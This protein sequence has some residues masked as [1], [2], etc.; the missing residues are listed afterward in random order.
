[1]ADRFLPLWPVTIRRTGFSMPDPL[2]D[3]LRRRFD[4]TP[5][6]SLCAFNPNGHQVVKP[7]QR[8]AATTAAHST[9]EVP[10]AN[11]ADAGGPRV[12]HSAPSRLPHSW[13]ASMLTPASARN[14]ILRR[15][16]QLPA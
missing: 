8:P 5:H 15:K 16:G 7:T 13:N 9:S 4:S 10:P 14:I 11:L 3:L 1:M 12:S 6:P 2:N